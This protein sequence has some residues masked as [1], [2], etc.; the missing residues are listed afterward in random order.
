MG[1]VVALRQ[2][3]IP[4]GVLMGVFWLHE[5]APAPKR[6]GVVLLLLGLVM[7]SL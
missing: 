6:C 2:A 3:S 5:S 4:I 1:Y 7:I